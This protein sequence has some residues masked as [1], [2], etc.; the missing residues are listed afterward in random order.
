MKTQRKYVTIS[1]ENEIKTSPMNMANWIEK[2]PSGLN[3][4]KEL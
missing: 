1:E 2:S 4:Q 3:P